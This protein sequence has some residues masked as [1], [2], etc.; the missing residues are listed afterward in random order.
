MSAEHALAAW[1]V[2]L[3]LVAL[4]AAT[5]RGARL[6]LAIA[7]VALAVPSFAV[8]SPFLSALLALAYL[9]GVV[10]AADFVF[11]RA[12]E[13]FIHR[14]LHLL[15]LVD[16][17]T[18]VRGAV[19]LKHGALL[20][21]LV[22]CALFWAAL[23]A[24]GA[25]PIAP[26]PLHY[27][28]RWTAGAVLALAGLEALAAALELAAAA[29]GWVT[30]PLHVAPHL[31]RSIGEFWG[32]RWNRIV[33]D[34]LRARAFVPLARRGP[35]LGLA[36]SF[37]LSAALHAYLIGFAL[38]P[39]AALA[40]AAFFLVQPLAIVAERRLG[41]RRWAPW[42]GHAWTVTVLGLLSPLMVEPALRALGA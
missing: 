5:P 13:R 29:A 17:R 14:A 12:P 15:A 34:V 23:V 42:A 35:M 10:R 6:G 21:L 16:T 37:A 30:P 31:A 28:V 4:L 24:A 3:V 9:W 41:V 27:A 25:A 19:R 18:L 7:T 20:R 8:A 1:C 33:S 2:E 40:W 38:G 32:Q 26:A 22:A 11:E 36:A 39:G